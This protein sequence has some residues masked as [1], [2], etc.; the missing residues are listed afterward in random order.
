MRYFSLDPCFDGIPW[1]LI[2]FF[3]H[4]KSVCVLILA[5]MEYLGNILFPYSFNNPF[6]CFV[7]C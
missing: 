1:K 5:L 4:E 2:Y 3:T 6:P 7:S